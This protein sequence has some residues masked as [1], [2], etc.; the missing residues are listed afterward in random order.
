MDRNDGSRPTDTVPH[1]PNRVRPPYADGL[2]LDANVLI[3]YDHADKGIAALAARHLGPTRVLSTTISEVDDFE[4][5]ECHR[6]GISIIEPTPAQ[7]NEADR[8]SSRTSREDKLCFVACRQ[9]GWTLATNDRLLR[10][11]CQRNEVPVRYALELVLDLFGIGHL[12]RPR[13]ESVARQFHNRSPNHY[14]QV[15]LD[16]FRSELDGRDRPR[17]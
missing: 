11:L 10:R 3:E 12:S 4:T 14:P 16:W 6:L 13:A 7:R 5:E 15:I 9:H 2:L 17:P 8:I 1:I